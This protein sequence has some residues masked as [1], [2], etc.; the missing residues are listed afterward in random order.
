MVC[1]T[2]GYYYGFCLGLRILSNV[3]WLEMVMSNTIYYQLLVLIPLPL[4]L[5]LRFSNL[6][7]GTLMSNQLKD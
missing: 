5:G 6:Q 3:L 2:I 1:D 7:T 4:P